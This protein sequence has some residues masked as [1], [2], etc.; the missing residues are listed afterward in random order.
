MGSDG[1]SDRPALVG[2]RP[3]ANQ[4]GQT[5][6]ALRQRIP[7]TRQSAG[8]RGAG[9]PVADRGRGLDVFVQINTSGEASK[10]GLQPA[11]AA[12]FVQALAPFSALRVRGLMTLALLSAETEKYVPVLRYCAHYANNCANPAP[13][14][15]ASTN[16]QW[17]CQAIS[18][19]PSK[20]VRPWC[21]LAK[22]FMVP[23][24]RQ[25]ITTG[26]TRLT[27]RHQYLEPPAGAT[28]L[29]AKQHEH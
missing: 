4:Q 16:S 27:Q 24:T 13:P 22:P 29:P 2:D 12:N 25:T 7:G 17:A 26:R 18:K 23:A 19:L 20:K 28:R 15:S 9:T 11:E 21:G 6:R 8:R 1:R 5:G 10:Y 14:A 3:F